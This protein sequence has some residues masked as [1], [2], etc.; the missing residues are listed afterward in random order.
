M[1]SLF[2]PPQFIKLW[3]IFLELNSERLYKSSLK[4]KET[5][6]FHDVVVQLPQKK[7]TKK[8]DVRAELLIC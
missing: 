6:K 2:H 7:W 4:E 5:T 8:R 3:Q 1:S